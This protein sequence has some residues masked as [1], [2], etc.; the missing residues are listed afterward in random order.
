M[1]PGSC[2]RSFGMFFQFCIF[3]YL[4]FMILY[5]AYIIFTFVL[6]LSFMGVAFRVFLESVNG[7]WFCAFL[8]QHILVCF[9]IFVFSG[10]NSLVYFCSW[11][12]SGL[13]YSLNPHSSLPCDSVS[14]LVHNYCPIAKLL[15]LLLNEQLFKIMEGKHLLYKHL[16]LGKKQ[17]NAALPVLMKNI[18]IESNL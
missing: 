2:F 5:S 16:I 15:S 12:Q 11:F 17:N 10:F 6:F 18:L 13:C 14:G 9:F 8:E 3:D 1:L 4:C 7:F